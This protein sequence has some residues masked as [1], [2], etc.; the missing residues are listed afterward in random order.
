MK[1]FP[2]ERRRET[3]DRFDRFRSDHHRLD[4]CKG[5]TLS[6]RSEEQDVDTRCNAQKSV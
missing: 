2:V 3:L 5:S 6:V 1:L 4:L